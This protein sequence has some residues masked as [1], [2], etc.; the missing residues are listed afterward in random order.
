MVRLLQRMPQSRVFCV[1]TGLFLSV[2]I[3]FASGDATNWVLGPF[4]RPPDAKPVIV[5]NKDSVF[6]G[7]DGRNIH[8]EILHT[9]NPAAVVRDGKIYVLYRSEDDSGEM[10]IRRP[11]FPYRTG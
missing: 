11:H 8:W 2:A 9:F 10:K 1:C 5:P 7:P 4:A 6:S 3:A